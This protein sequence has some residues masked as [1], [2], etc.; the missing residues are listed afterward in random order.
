MLES[1][2]ENILFGNAEVIFLLYKS[3]LKHPKLNKKIFFGVLIDFYKKTLYTLNVYKDY[4]IV[5]AITTHKV[6]GFM[7]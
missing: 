2:E 1:K 7:A 5:F 6:F 4:V 3:S